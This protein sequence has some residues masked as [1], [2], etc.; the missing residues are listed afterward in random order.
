MGNFRFSIRQREAK[1][2]KEE[3][4]AEKSGVKENTEEGEQTERKEENAMVDTRRARRDV[5]AY[6][7]VITR[8]KKNQQW[9]R[10][11]ADV[12]IYGG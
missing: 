6:D 11:H 9:W 4:G 7:L 8:Q 10:R 1:P 12:R 2:I 3:E 5:G